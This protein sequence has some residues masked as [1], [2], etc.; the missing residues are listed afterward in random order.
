[1]YTGDVKSAT[2]SPESE[3]VDHLGVRP[4]E[5]ERQAGEVVE[6]C[7]L[8]VGEVAGEAKSLGVQHCQGP[9]SVTDLTCAQKR[10]YRVSC[11][12][13]TGG[14]L[15]WQAFQPDGTAFRSFYKSSAC[16]CLAMTRSLQ[17]S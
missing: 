8:P 4:A 10:T 15:L 2:G 9:V 14:Q 12:W 7:K 11:C 1:M 16:H 5:V 6:T 3:R 17:L 13:P